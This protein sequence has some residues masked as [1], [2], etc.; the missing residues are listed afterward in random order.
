MPSMDYAK[1]LSRILAD[2][3]LLELLI[4]WVIFREMC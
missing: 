3:F 1:Y 2:A 4:L